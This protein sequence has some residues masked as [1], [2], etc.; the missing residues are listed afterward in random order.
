M[1]VDVLMP[2]CVQRDKLERKV[3]KVPPFGIG[4]GPFEMNASWYF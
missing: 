3:V 1:P 4:K 2:T